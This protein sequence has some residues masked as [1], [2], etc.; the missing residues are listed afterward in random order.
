MALGLK[1]KSQ[2]DERW[3]FLGATLLSFMDQY[4]DSQIKLLSL[5]SL[6]KFLETDFRQKSI[7]KQS[8]VVVAE[9]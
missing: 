2:F 1:I 4:Y 5:L 6:A 8:W 3:K 7:L 9:V